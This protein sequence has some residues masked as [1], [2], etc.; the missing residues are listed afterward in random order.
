MQ[1]KVVTKKTNIF[2]N[3]MIISEKIILHGR[4]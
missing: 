2:F 1:Y 4:K 3:L